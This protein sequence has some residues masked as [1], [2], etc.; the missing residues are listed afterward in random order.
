M[1]DDFLEHQRARYE[2]G[3]KATIPYCINHCLVNNRPIPPWLATAFREAYEKVHRFEVKSWD[4]VF[5]RPLKKGMQIEKE[6]KYMQIAS[7]SST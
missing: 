1:T 6:R 7:R 3:D 2:A 5:D 4:D